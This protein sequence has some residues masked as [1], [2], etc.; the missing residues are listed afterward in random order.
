MGSSYL[1][2]PEQHTHYVILIV[3]PRTY[4]AFYTYIHVANVV[5]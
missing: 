4:V 2:V 5:L 3:I 1:A